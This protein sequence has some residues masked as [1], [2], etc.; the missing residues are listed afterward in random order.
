[1]A[2]YRLGNKISIG[3]GNKEKNMENKQKNK[4]NIGVNI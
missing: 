2:R 4:Q 1:M 3:S